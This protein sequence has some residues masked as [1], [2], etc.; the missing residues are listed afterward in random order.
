MAFWS[1]LD[2]AVLAADAAGYLF[3]LAAHVFGLRRTGH[4]RTARVILLSLAAGAIIVAAVYTV[5]F[6]RA[7]GENGGLVF[8]TGLSLAGILYGF[9]G[10]H[11]VAWIFG[12]GEAAVRIRLLRSLEAHP[13]GRATLEE[14]KRDYN[15]EN[16]LKIRLERLTGSGHLGMSGGRYVVRSRVVLLQ[17]AVTQWLKKGL[18]LDGEN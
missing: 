13:E 14:I 9:L 6:R 15:A 18:G 4:D 3:F 8:L 11:Y 2:S 10:F 17:A 12:M 1:S 16:V 7:A 5:V